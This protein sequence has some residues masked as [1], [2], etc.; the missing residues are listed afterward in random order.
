[1]K[2]DET[3]DYYIK[4]NWHALT[5]LYNGIAAEYGLTQATGFVLLNIED[6]VGT[7]A[8]KIAPLMGM[9][10]TSLSRVLKNMEEAGLII[11]K[12]DKSD[13]RMVRVHLTELGKEKK[14]I[15][16]KVVRELNTYIIN[17]IPEKKLS[18]YFEVMND[19]SRLITNYKENK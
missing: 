16:K 2:P 6:N 15:A 11:R 4:A 1:M 12:G 19:I 14:S 9:K 5:N 8:T 3:V 17:H 10:A 18:T 13:G 7:P